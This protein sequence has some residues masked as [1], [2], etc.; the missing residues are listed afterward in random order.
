MIV[1]MIFKVD[2]CTDVA[3]LI[4]DMKSNGVDFFF[5]LFATLSNYFSNIIVF[6]SAKKFLFLFP[7]FIITRGLIRTWY[8]SENKDRYIVGNWAS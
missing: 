7:F 6:N 1:K 5:H 8:I 3:L 4:L 2:S